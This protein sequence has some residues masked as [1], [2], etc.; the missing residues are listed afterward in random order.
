[1]RI[2]FVDD[3]RLV[4]DAIERSLFQVDGWEIECATSGREALEILSEGEHF[5]VVVSDMR[6]PGMDGAELLGRVLE[7]HPDSVRMVLS[8]HTEQEAAMRTIGVAHQ[9]LAKPCGAGVL[10]RAIER[11]L[12]LQALL[13]SDAVRALV[14]RVPAL[15]TVPDTYSRLSRVLAEPDVDFKAVTEVIESD[16]ALC[17]KLLQVVNSAFFAQSEPTREIH[18]AVV[19]LGVNT[20]RGL[21][22]SL[23]V[24][25]KLEP[26]RAVP[27]FSLERER[28]HATK[29]ARLAASLYR[30]PARRAAPFMAAMLHDV[31]KLIL[32]AEAPETLSQSLQHAKEH[33]MTLHDA[34]QA[35]FGT[36][37]AEVGAYLLGLWCLPEDVVLG[38]AHHHSPHR[39]TPD[40]TKLEVAHAIYI[41]NGVLAKAPL[42]D[43]ELKSF[44]CQFTLRELHAR[45]EQL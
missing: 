27:G 17:A 18:A 1:M 14:D 44:G 9:F 8:G 34:E 29:V 5:D 16:P 39:I 33:G 26:K 25:A 2:L 31:G 24:I 19:K 45:A 6:M 10:Q 40:P 28:T 42:D 30:T 36:S 22:L 4:L 41:A 12:E 13:S 35:L 43:E 21:V 20:L 7:S 32:A 23:E 3:E 38:V 15:P 37:H 11:T